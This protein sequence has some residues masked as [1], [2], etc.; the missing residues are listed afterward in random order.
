MKTRKAKARRKRK[1]EQDKF[2]DMRDADTDGMNVFHQGIHE[3][4][5][6]LD[7]ARWLLNEAAAAMTA[8]RWFAL[9]RRRMRA[10]EMLLREAEEL[11]IVWKSRVEGEAP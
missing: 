3:A 2:L 11:E 5:W 8:N 6:Q 7:L 9:V 10:A 1:S 4:A